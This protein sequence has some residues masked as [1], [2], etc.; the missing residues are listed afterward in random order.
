MQINI[1][2]LKRTK[3]NQFF[4]HDLLE[5]DKLNSYLVYS[6]RHSTFLCEN[7]FALI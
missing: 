5:F 2:S 3:N 1:I 4:D 6:K 7:C